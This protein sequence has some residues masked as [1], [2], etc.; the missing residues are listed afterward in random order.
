M[1]FRPQPRPAL[2]RSFVA[3][4]QTLR[5]VHQ[6]T[7]GQFGFVLAGVNPHIVEAD[8]V[9]RF[10]NPLLLYNKTILPGTL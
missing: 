8:R 5:S 6:D 2:G 9:G 3:L 7:Q 1:S 10:D 4:W